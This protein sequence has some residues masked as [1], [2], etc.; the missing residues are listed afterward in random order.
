MLAVVYYS[1]SEKVSDVE[2]CAFQLVKLLEYWECYMITELRKKF[3]K[4]INL[5]LSERA[6][7]ES[8]LPTDLWKKPVSN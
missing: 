6:R 5:V 8:A 4:E 2:C 7:I 1:Q 3:T